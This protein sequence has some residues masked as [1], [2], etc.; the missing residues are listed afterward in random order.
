[1]L[2]IYAFTSF[3]SDG[4]E[5]GKVGILVSGSLEFMTSLQQIFDFHW[6]K[7]NLYYGLQRLIELLGCNR[8]ELQF[9]RQSL[10]RSTIC[11]RVVR[12]KTPA[13]S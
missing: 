10:F 7:H 8:L 13:L 12:G 6:I 4:R 2:G 3:E 1:M 9:S 5:I 11:A